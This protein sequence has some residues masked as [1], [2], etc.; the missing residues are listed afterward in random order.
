M[1]GTAA[2]RIE[3]VAHDDAGFRLERAY[4]LAAVIA[5]AGAPT[6][7]GSSDALVTV[8][9]DWSG[10]WYWFI[11]RRMVGTVDRE[12]GKV[13]THQ[14]EGERFQN[15]FAVG[16]DG[17]FVVTDH[18]LYALHRRSRDRGAAVTWRERTIAGPTGSSARS[19][20]ARVRRRP[21]SATSGSRS[22]TTP[23]R[24]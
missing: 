10:R 5:P 20:R 1:I 4:D 2:H 9:P 16:P 6:T 3:V 12:S 22:R 24:A 18:A 11:T 15:S 17:A 7:P 23:S 8:L 13:E 19:T 14:L 21:S